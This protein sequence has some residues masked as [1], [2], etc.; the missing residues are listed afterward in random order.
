MNPTDKLLESETKKWLRRLEEKPLPKNH[1]K[2][3][4]E[5][6][7]N[8][9]AYISDCKHFLSKKDFIRA[10]EAIMYAWGIYETL[11]SMHLI[12]DSSQDQ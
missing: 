3:V 1:D 9:R 10:F 5:Q 2:A 7:V 11:L 6:L 4:E 8:V 12:K